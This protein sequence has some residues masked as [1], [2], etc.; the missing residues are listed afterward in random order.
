MTDQQINIAIAESLGWTNINHGTV[1]YTARMPN[2]KWDIIPNYTADL[3]TC[4][5]L[6]KALNTDDAHSYYWRLERELG[7]EYASATARQRC[8][9]YLRTIEKWKEKVND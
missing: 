8:E 2:G 1:Q 7:W 9:A 6:E 4:H 3:N 5:E